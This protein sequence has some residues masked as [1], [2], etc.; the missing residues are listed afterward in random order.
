[1]TTQV[2]LK[3]VT[4]GTPKVKEFAATD[5]IAASNLDAS[6]LTLTGTAAPTNKDL[7][8]PTNKSYDKHWSKR[9][10][11]YYNDANATTWTNVGF[12]AAPTLSSN[13]G[14]FVSKNNDPIGQLCRFDTSAVSG[15]AQG[16]ITASFDYTQRQWNP[17]WVCT[18]R[19]HTAITSACFLVGLFDQNI[20]ALVVAPSTQH[21]ALFRYDTGLDTTGQWSTVTCDGTTPTT[22]TGAGCAIA[23]AT[24]YTLRLMLKAAAVDFYINDA[25]VFS[26]TTHLPGSTTNL[27]FGAR[28]IARSASARGLHVGQVTLLAA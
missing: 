14:T 24:A 6:L 7:S 21:C 28:V 10:Q 23:T 12:K 15:N 17:E 20:D 19:T 9:V 27:G 26:H 16:L 8:D 4:G 11:S 22:N 18:V 1:M 3:L 25:L 2:P 5:T 13:G